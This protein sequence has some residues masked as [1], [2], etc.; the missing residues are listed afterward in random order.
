MKSRS[1]KK[2]E[3]QRKILVAASKRLRREGLRGASVAAVMDDA[4]LTHGA[5]YSHFENKGELARAALTEALQ[6]NRKRWTARFSSGSWSSHLSKLASRYLTPKHRDN[7]D[8]GCA[9]AA[10]CSE[11][12][13]SDPEFQEAYEAELLKTLR[14]IEAQ[15]PDGTDDQKNEDTLAFFSLLVGSMALSRAVSSNELSDQILESA[16]KAAGRLASEGVES[17]GDFWCMEAG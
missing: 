3:S 13:R 17:Y 15:G 10:L 6:E 8:D 9:L 1:E 7:L 16:K 2:W 14:A 11:T 4:G 5:F 12:A